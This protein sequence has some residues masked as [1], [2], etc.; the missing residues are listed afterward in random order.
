MIKPISS[1]LEI[2]ALKRIIEEVSILRSEDHN[3]IE[4]AIASKEKP[5][6][7]VEPQLAYSPVCTFSKQEN[8][9][10]A[11]EERSNVGFRLGGN[12]TPVFWIWS[13]RSSWCPSICSAHMDDIWI[14]DLR[15]N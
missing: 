4:M 2:E 13:P 5:V 9:T 10:V 6:L 15:S 1:I 12:I 11:S 8:F 7:P 14:F 3:D